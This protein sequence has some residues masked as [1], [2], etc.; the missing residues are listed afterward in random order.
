[1]R[2]F[3]PFS[4]GSTV[5]LDRLENFDGHLREPAA[6]HLRA[7]EPRERRRF[8]PLEPHR[9]HHRVR[10][11]GDQAGAVVDL[12]QAAGHREAAFGKMISVSPALTALISERVAIGLVGSS[13]M[14]RVS[15]RNG[16]THQRLAMP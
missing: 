12:H 7:V 11:V 9:H 4:S 1:M 14:A 2:R 10:L 5:E 8:Q 16:F 13:G 6:A 3:L 15:F